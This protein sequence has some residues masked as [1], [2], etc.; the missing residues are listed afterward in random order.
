[1]IK[2]DPKLKTN[3]AFNKLIYKSII[4]NAPKCKYVFI[5]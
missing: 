5:F 4:I 1:M 3:V 2:Y